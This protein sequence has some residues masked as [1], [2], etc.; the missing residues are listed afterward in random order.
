MNDYF[1]RFRNAPVNFKKSFGFLVT[2]WVCHP[3]FLYSLFWRQQALTGVQSEMKKMVIVSISLC[4]FIFLIKKWARALVVMGSCFILVYDLM[5]F[6]T[7]PHD[8]ISTIL[9]VIIFLFSIVGTYFLFAK[10][11]RDY[12][13][14]MN[15]KPESAGPSNM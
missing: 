3:I 10:D 5:W 13:N 6:L 2:A 8:K 7:V 12:F 9:C 15:P 4:F 14:R 1:D 11:V